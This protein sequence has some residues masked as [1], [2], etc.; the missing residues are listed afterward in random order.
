[1]ALVWDRFRKLDWWMIGAILLLITLSVVLM[2]GIE[3]G[4]TDESSTFVKQILFGVLGLMLFF[5]FS[6][7]NYRILQNYAY[8]LYGAGVVVLVSVLLFGT[9]IRGTTGWFQFGGIS[10]QPVEFAKILLVIALARYFSDHIF[11]FTS[12]KVIAYAF[13]IVGLYAALVLRQPDLG[14]AAVFIAAFGVLLWLTNIRFKQLAII[15]ATGLIVVAIAWVALLEDYQKDR[16][17]TFL[18]PARDPLVSGYNVTQAIVSVGSGQFFGRGLGL[19]TQSQLHFL[20]ER[21]SDFIFA[22]I[23][24]ELGFVGASIVILLIAIIL[25][26]LWIIMRLANDDYTKYLAAGIGLII[27]FQSLINIGMNLGVL[28]VTGIPLPLVSAGGSSMLAILSALGIAQNCRQQIGRSSYIQSK[29]T[30]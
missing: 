20:P 24:E 9:T 25:W 30:L 5:G 12:W 16:V 4:P 10:V 7:V 18:D 19:G 14:S 11:H 29:K 26:R 28:P 2:Y 3:S 1:M 22:V 21:E 17:L 6:F 8:I 15:I 13:S 23:A 27:F